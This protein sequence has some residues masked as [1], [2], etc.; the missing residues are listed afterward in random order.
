MHFFE[1]AARPLPL[2]AADEPVLR[3]VALDRTPPVL[4]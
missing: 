2:S 4:G 1:R 3:D